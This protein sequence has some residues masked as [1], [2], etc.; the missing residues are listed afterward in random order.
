MKRNEAT[1]QWMKSPFRGKRTNR[2]RAWSM[3][4]RP[5]AGEGSAG[6]LW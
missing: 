5:E 6:V 1:A 2:L 3:E 4:G